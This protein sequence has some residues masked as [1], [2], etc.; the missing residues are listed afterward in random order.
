MLKSGPD[1]DVIRRVF[2]DYLDQPRWLEWRP[3]PDQSGKIEKVPY[4]AGT[5]Y[6]ASHSNPKHWRT[7]EQC[8]GERR[9]PVF[10]GDGLGGVDLDGCRDPG[11]WRADGVGAGGPRR[12]R[13]LRRGVA[14]R[15][16]R[17]GLR[18]GCAGRAAMQC[19]ADAGRAH[20]RQAAATR[21]LS[22]KR[23]FTL[24]GDKLP[25]APDEIRA[26]P[27][28]WARLVERLR[29]QREREGR[30]PAAGRNGR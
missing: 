10:N 22:T 21:G 6:K 20:Q 19:A 9:G 17:E 2:R 30:R 16:R 1:L 24:T 27:E 25:G 3:E 5:N 23:Y 12:L 14:V 26:A 15:Q 28:A 11:Q 18:T 7:F 8:R 13:L 4:I 29:E